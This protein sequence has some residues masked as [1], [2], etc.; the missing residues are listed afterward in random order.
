MTDT[1][2]VYGPSCPGRS[3]MEPFD[4]AAG[5][6]RWTARDLAFQAGKLP[7][8]KGDWAP[9]PECKS[10]VAVMNECTGVIQTSM[11]VFSS[12]DMAQF[13]MPEANSSMILS[14]TS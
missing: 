9:G 1:G 14:V 6:I 2:L 3:D 8:D 4:A 12:G 5:M 11:P 10:A 7:A 13:A